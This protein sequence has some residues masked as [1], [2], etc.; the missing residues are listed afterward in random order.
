MTTR[1]GTALCFV[2]PHI[3]CPC[4]RL[5]MLTAALVSPQ[6]FVRCNCPAIII[7]CELNSKT[8]AVMKTE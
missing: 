7:L 3:D 5:E 4:T 6:H 2:L 8:F 1:R